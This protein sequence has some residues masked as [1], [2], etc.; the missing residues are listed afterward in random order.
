MAILPGALTPD[1]YFIVSGHYDSRGS[2]SNGCSFNIPAPG[3][4][5]DGSGTAA[6]LELARVFSRYT[7][8]ASLIF[9]TV[10]GEEE[11]LYGAE[12]YAA[13]AQANGLRIDGM[14]TNDI[15]GNVRGSNNVVDSTRVRSYS[16]VNDATHHRQ[17]SRYL[18]LKSEFFYP[19]MTVTLM[20]AV[21]RPGRGGD[22]MPFQNHGFAAARFIEPN[23]NTTNQHTTTDIIANMSPS[24]NARVA[25][26][27][28]AGLAS[29]AWAPERPAQPTVS[30]LGTGTSLLVQWPSTNTEPD[31]AGYRIAVRDSGGLFYNSFVDAGNVH[32]IVVNGLTQDV[33]VYIG[34]SAYDVEGNESIFSTERLGRPTFDGGLPIQL[35]S[36]SA[37]AQS[38]SGVLVQWT[39]IS[40]INN[41]GFF[42]QRRRGTEAT[43]TQLANSF[44]PGHG[45]TNEPHQYNYTDDDAG[46]GTWYYR[47]KSVDLDGT[48][49]LTEA[50]RVDVLTGVP[51]AVVPLQ[52]RLLQNYP[53]PFN[54]S[55]TIRFELASAARV[56][57]KVLNILGEEVAELVNGVR[58]AG[59]HTSFFNASELPAG[60]YFCTLRAMSPVAGDLPLYTR[61]MKLMLV[62]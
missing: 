50:I 36:F 28:A 39:T 35:G 22:H 15:I 42:V 20:P 47:L 58:A 5:D 11:G 61:T 10:T 53:N 62:K 34:V 41:Y 33:A 24:Y 48:E 12:A 44:T 57:L 29:L 31:L 23:E 17:L 4:N 55:T 38:T 51:G 49:H 37:Q 59:V 13:Y 30:N 40:E 2:T 14:I 32:Q 45:T 43:F 16:S 3:A 52:T 54:P 6:S 9:M 18:K 21:D 46:P 25:R 8:D 19:A 56:T 7:F 27:N 26:V 60:V 1:R